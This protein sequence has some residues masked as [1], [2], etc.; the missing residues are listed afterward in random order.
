MAIAAQPPEFYA[1]KYLATMVAK[2]A[3]MYGKKTVRV[4]GLKC[5]HL[6]GQTSACLAVWHGTIS[7]KRVGVV[8]KVQGSRV[9][10]NP[11][12]LVEP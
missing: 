5:F 3:K 12:G 8:L 10:E 9:T 1:A 11:Y 4:E 7:G 6:T 2:S